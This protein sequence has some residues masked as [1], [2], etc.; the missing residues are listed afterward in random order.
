MNRFGFIYFLID[1]RT[2]DTRYVGKTGNKLNRRL[3]SHVY[4]AKSDKYNHHCSCWIRSLYLLTQSVLNLFCI[5][6]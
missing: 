4:D 2:F 5:G 1:P 3:N 6:R